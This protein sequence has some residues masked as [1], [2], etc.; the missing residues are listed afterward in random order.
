MYSFLA[1]VDPDSDFLHPS[2]YGLAPARNFY[3]I[4]DDGVSLGVWHILPHNFISSVNTTD[5]QEP[6]P[7]AIFNSGQDIVI[8]CHGNAGNR[9]NDYRIAL[10]AVL[11]RHFHVI[12]FDYR[13]RFFDVKNIKYFFWIKFKIHS[14]YLKIL[15]GI[16]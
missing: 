7:D 10:Y 5:E 8:Y 4:T 1:T 13:S 15:V 16:Y 9:V 12:T 3:L 11:R 2:K 6:Y 14:I